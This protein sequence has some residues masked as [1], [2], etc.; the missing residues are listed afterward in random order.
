[1]L[2]E[3]EVTSQVTDRLER[4]YQLAFFILGSPEAAERI[5]IEAVDRL[6]VAVATQDRRYYYIPQGSQRQLGRTSG[7]RSKVNFSELHL[8]QRLIFDG[9]ECEEK[10]Q[11]AME[12]DDHRLLIHFLKHLVRITIKRN[13]FYV[14]LGIARLLHRYSI[15]EAIS[16]HG[17]VM[18]NPGRA[19]DNYYWRSRKSQLLQEMKTRFGDLLTLTRGA[20]GEE[21]FIPRPNQARYADLV[22]LCL[23]QFMPWEIQCPLPQGEAHVSDRI[24]AL[25]FDGDDP[26]E[27]HRTEVMR[28]HAVLHAQC[29][30]RL[31]A[32]LRFDSP[33]TR[34]DLPEFFHHTT[35]NQQFTEDSFQMIETK[36]MNPGAMRAKLEAR[37]NQRRSLQQKL[38]AVKILVDHQPRATLDL[39]TDNQIDFKWLE[40][41]EFLEIR[42]GNEPGICLALYPIDYQMLQQAHTP[43]KFVIELAGGQKLNF[44]LTPE[45]DAEGE[46][47]GGEV[48]VT[49]PKPQS[50]L[51]DWVRRLWPASELSFQA[52]PYGRYVFL[53][54]LLLI[55]GFS[56]IALWRF[57]Q[58]DSTNLTASN[59]QPT[60]SQTI[61]G[62]ATTPNAEPA[63]TTPNNAASPQRPSNPPS[64]LRDHDVT[65]NEA[66]PNI[67]SPKQ[68]RHVF[69]SLNR[70][71]NEF[72]SELIKRLKEARL[73][74]LT[75]KEEADTALDI[76]L[77]PTGQSASVRLINAKGHIIWPRSGKSQKYDG[78]VARISERIVADLKIAAGQ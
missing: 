73:W 58:T 55:C 54:A 67:E 9:T 29:F 74:E 62:N 70:D 47:I 34:L 31:I 48:S 6:Q 18:Q 11:E 3:V 36:P 63:V 71:V 39:T 76:S 23:E 22:T 30:E 2:G 72:R 53:A 14:S 43:T 61:S 75:N 57:W 78:D 19:K 37:Q 20:Y 41:E 17:L 51:A 24:P 65:D 27:E 46:V 69:L 15:T 77:S 60:I 10:E 64:T 8:L 12:I 1:M 16:L 52:S 56:S 45:R 33:V 42:A 59:R 35:H 7:A 25:D 32:A 50:L 4:A 13:S 44:V 5:A 68:T 49:Y 38:R 40:G 21:R 28:M 26:D 66:I